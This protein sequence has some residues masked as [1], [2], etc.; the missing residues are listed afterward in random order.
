MTVHMFGETSISYWLQTQGLYNIPNAEAT[1]AD[2]Y[3]IFE[4]YYYNN[5]L[6]DR[7]QQALYDQ[8]I[9]TPGMKPL[10]NPVHRL[11]EFYVAKIW[12]G[13]L[14]DALQIVTDNEE[15]I[16]PIHQLWVWSNWSQKKQLAVRHLAMLGDFFIRVATHEPFP[17]VVDRVYLQLIKPHYVTEVKDDERGYTIYIR[18]DIPLIRKEG[19]RKTNYIHTEVWDK[20][21][22]S[23]TIW[24]HTKPAN[25]EI[26]DL[27]EPLSQAAITD[28][29]ID[30]VPFVQA[31]FQD[32]GEE[33]GACAFLHALDKIDEANRQA[34][35]LHQMLFRY[36]KPIFAL[37]ANGIDSYNRPL[38]PPT[39]GDGTS[40]I[41]SVGDDDLLPLPGN[42]SI[43]AMVPQLNY[44]DALAIL[45]EMLHEVKS[46]LP[47]LVYYHI[48]ELGGEL[49][50]RALRLMMSAA[51]DR[52]LEVRAN[53]EAALLRAQQMALTLG[54]NYGLFSNIGNYETG[55]LN[56]TFA[57]RD[58]IPLDDLELA[59]EVV[60]L[61]DAEVPQATAL[62]RV[63]WS[64]DE[65]KQ[66]D[67]D[68]K[69]DDKRKQ[70]SLGQQMLNAQR[71]F[72]A[73]NVPGRTSA[74]TTDD[75]ED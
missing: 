30:F 6:Y 63:G 10:R 17:G 44:A 18:L 2:W 52:V 38:P 67:K 43:A 70:A 48:Q 23:V 75:G 39:L 47:E 69:A 11:V 50:G 58:V 13:V 24:E 57:P 72:N 53:A 35:R 8:A 62:R 34:T 20:A 51:V 55:E 40:S 14:P 65:L 66:L 45:N 37:Q 28:S 4:M 5:G 16:D 49:S 60:R 26:P 9:W 46:D 74:A 33:R 15:I 12:P 73:G 1:W 54:K 19:R 36:N 59:E 64:E 61:M 56:H 21:R 41:V 3:R 7:V 25:T 31:K 29:G 42:A 71:Q 27:G 22:N 68:R 32:V